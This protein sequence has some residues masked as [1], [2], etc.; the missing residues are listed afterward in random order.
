MPDVH[1][2]QHADVVIITNRHAMYIAI[3]CNAHVSSYE[4]N[5][6]SFIQLASQLASYK[7]VRKICTLTSRMH[8]HKSEHIYFCAHI[9]S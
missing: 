1:G 6:L 4:E 3:V 7:R 2:N 9:A 8:T 5:Y